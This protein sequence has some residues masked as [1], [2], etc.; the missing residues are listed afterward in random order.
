MAN[1]ERLCSAAEQK[2]AVRVNVEGSVGVSTDLSEE[3]TGKETVKTVGALARAT[4]DSTPRKA[5]KHAPIK[6]C[7]M[8]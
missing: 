4:E 1:D 8:S 3:S 7:Q 2:E 6:L 5:E